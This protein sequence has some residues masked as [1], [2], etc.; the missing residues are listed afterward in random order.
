MAAFSQALRAAVWATPNFFPFQYEAW[1]PWRL[2][3]TSH[4][5]LPLSHQS[6]WNV[7]EQK[8]F[9]RGVLEFRMSLFDARNTFSFGVSFRKCHLT[10]QGTTCPPSLALDPWNFYYYG[11][12]LQNL[13]RL[14]YIFITEGQFLESYRQY[15]SL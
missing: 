14:Y 7:K 10:H 13:S 8:L 15:R 5:S 3:P 9:L 6:H 11:V 1:P 4:Q 2:R 12:T